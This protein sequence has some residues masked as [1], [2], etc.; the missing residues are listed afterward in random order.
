VLNEE[1]VCESVGVGDAIADKGFISSVDHQPI[2]T[3]F[4]LDVDPS[5][6]EPEFMLEYEA[7]FGDEH[8]DD[9]AD[10]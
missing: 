4:A 1:H 6:V 5:F 7:T 10:D 2:A 8:A 9:S 3:G